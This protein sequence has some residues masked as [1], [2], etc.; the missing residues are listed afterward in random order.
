MNIKYEIDFKRK[1]FTKR[2]IRKGAYF[3]IDQFREGKKYGFLDNINETKKFISFSYVKI[4][5]LNSFVLFSKITH[6]VADFSDILS[7]VGLQKAE[8]LTTIGEDFL[9]V[10][11]PSKITGEERNKINQILNLTIPVNENSNPLILVIQIT[12]D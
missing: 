1:G 9:C 12:E 6:K 2:D 3:L 4:A 10:L 8:P 11:Y 5:G 7:K